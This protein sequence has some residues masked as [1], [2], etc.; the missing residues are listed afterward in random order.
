[1][2]TLETHYQGPRLWSGKRFLQL[3][4]DG[5]SGKGHALDQSGDA[6]QTH[7]VGQAAKRSLAEQNRSLF[8]NDWCQGCADAI[9]RIPVFLRE[10]E[11]ESRRP[12]NLLY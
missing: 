12:H 2:D 6:G 11:R 4:S 5:M 7:L 1:M 10:R 9:E 8:A 3:G